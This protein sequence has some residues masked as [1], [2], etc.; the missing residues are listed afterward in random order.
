MLLTSVRLVGDVGGVDTLATATDLD[1][2][3]RV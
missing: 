3:V 1:G 2:N